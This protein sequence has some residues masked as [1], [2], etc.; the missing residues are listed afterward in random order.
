MPLRDRDSRP[1]T[2]PTIES[3]I[4][5]QIGCYALFAGDRC[6][7]VGHGDLRAELLARIT[8]DPSEP[9]CHRPTHWYA[10]SSRFPEQLAAELRVLLS[11]V[12]L[13]SGSPPP[14]ATELS[15]GGAEG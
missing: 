4:P 5:N 11:P 10:W 8:A 9:E 12:G 6:L 2:I 1:Y 13:G 7:Y 15:G 14:I 3:L